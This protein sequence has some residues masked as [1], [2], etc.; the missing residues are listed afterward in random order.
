[1]PCSKYE[2]AQ[3]GLC[4]ATKEWTALPTKEWEN[5][6]DIIHKDLKVKKIQTGEI[7]VK[8]VAGRIPTFTLQQKREEEK[9]I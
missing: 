8:G 2:G 5:W 7:K 1:M 3:R 9:G 6:D 4:F